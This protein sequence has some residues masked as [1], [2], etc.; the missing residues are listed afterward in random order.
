M[1]KNEKKAQV[2]VETVIYTLLGLVLIGI[3]LGVALPR[4]NEMK[5][6]TA[7]NEARAAIL[8][9]DDL[10]T[11]VIENVGGNSR[12]AAIRVQNGKYEINPTEKTIIYK[13]EDTKYKYS[14]PGEVIV[15]G[16]LKEITTEKSKGIYDIQFTIGYEKYDNVYL[17]YES[18]QK[19]IT[20]T[21][22]KTPYRI[23][24]QNLGTI[25]IGGVKKIQ[26]NIEPL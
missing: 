25:D 8:E 1:K 5:D 11:E 20:L 16:N 13:L 24:V 18:A 22:A 9:L 7:I 19:I 17:T 12:E 21:P 10:F 26:I 2:W 3:V 4:I 15:Y 23:L 14:Q 6:K